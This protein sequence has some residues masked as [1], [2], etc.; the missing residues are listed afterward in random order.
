MTSTREIKRKLTEGGFSDKQ[1]FCLLDLLAECGLITSA[2]PEHDLNLI[3]D[4]LT[5]V[6]LCLLPSGA[7]KRILLSP[8]RGRRD[9]LGLARWRSGQAMG[10]EAY[11]LRNMFC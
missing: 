9:G 7:G 2:D 5:A 8:G 6:L 4:K 3:N 11:C 10:V 1:S